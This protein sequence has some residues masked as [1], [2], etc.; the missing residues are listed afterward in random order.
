MFERF[1][2]KDSA[3]SS[4]SHSGLGLAIVKA[5]SELLGFDVQSR[6][7]RQQIVSITLSF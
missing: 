2:R 5:F 3:R 6:I 1:W 4:G 7:D